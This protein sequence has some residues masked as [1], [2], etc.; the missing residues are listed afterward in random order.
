MGRRGGSRAGQSREASAANGA[1]AGGPRRRSAAAGRR[2][3]C[4][5][6]PPESARGRGAALNGPGP[7]P[8]HGRCRASLLLQIPPPLPSHAARALRCLQVWHWVA[9]ASTVPAVR[10]RIVTPQRS[11]FRQLRHLSCCRPLRPAVTRHR[12]PSRHRTECAAPPFRCCAARPPS[13][14]PMASQP[15]PA[16]HSQAAATTRQ[17]SPGFASVTAPHSTCPCCT[18]RPLPS[19]YR[20]ASASPPSAAHPTRSCPAP[21][22]LCAT[23]PVWHSLHRWTT[24]ST[25]HS[26]AHATQTVQLPGMLES[27][28][29]H[30]TAALGAQQHWHQPATQSSHSVALV[31]AGPTAL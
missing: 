17:R 24:P 12:P 7:L 13:T 3:A 30:G 26:T 29:S 19:H 25:L 23:S 11:T 14:A 22:Q 21:A 18:V 10:L 20:L 2:C 5:V 1:R 8:P 28:P 16:P 27:P 4:A 31:L 15:C 6:R 9:P